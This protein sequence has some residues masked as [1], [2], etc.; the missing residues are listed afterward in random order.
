MGV[1]WIFFA[2]FYVFFFFLNGCF[3]DV[4]MGVLWICMVLDGFIW[5]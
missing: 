1:L 5:F 2:F 3:M 4:L